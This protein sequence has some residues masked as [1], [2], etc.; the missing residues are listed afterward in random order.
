MSGDEVIG[1]TVATLDFDGDWN[2]GDADLYP[3]IALADRALERYEWNA[4]KTGSRVVEVRLLP[5][6]RYDELAQRNDQAHQAGEVC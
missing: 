2:V 1:Y 5:L 3:T 4:D 6:A